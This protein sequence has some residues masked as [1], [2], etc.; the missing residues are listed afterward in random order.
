MVHWHVSRVLVAISFEILVVE[1]TGQIFILYIGI[2]I[3]KKF[4]F[5]GKNLDYILLPV[6]LCF[7]KIW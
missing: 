3:S 4:N 6:C 7:N 2:L 1:Q 5:T